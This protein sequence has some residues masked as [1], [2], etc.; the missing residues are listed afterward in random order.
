M[1]KIQVRVVLFPVDFLAFC[2]KW[3][4]AVLYYHHHSG[5]KWHDISAPDHNI[6]YSLPVDGHT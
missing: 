4:V 1:I 6:W 5:V 2:F 3:C